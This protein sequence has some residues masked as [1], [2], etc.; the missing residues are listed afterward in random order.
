MSLCDHTRFIRSSDASYNMVS[1]NVEIS[2]GVLDYDKESEVLKRALRELEGMVH[3]KDEFTIGDP[4]FSFGWYFFTL[5][6][7]REL[8]VKLA[9]LLGN[10]FLKVKGKNV[11]KKFV[12][13]LDARLKKLGH[14]MKIDLKA[15][16]ESSKYGLF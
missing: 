3:L 4:Q 7:S 1:E 2:V 5:S 12:N 8:V 9:N 11:E 15:E 16:I 6:V 13:W 10:E 14:E